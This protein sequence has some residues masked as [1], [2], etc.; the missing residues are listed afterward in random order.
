MKY[1]PDTI[2]LLVIVFLPVVVTVA[3]MW[4]LFEL[5]IKWIDGMRK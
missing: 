4:I 1:I 2:V 3:L 5:V